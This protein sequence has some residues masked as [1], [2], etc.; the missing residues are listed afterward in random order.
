MLIF[1]RCL[2]YLYPPLYRREFADEM[3]SVFRDMQADVLATSFLERILFRVRETE[4]LL[5]GALHEHL[6]IVTGGDQ[7][8][9]FTRS[10]MRPEFRFP[11][12]TVF[13]MLLI[14]GGV[15]VAMDKANTIQLKYAAGVGSV[16][17]SLP[18]FLGFT[19]LFT[20]V[21][22]VVVWGILFVLGRDGG[23]RLANIDTAPNKTN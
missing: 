12:S 3:I 9:S 4:G 21:G 8:I 18:W 22:A 16:W 2:L 5:A 19:L 1:Y 13:L 20:S 23:H 17:P 15:I 10:D 6:R 7:S 11:R 14:F